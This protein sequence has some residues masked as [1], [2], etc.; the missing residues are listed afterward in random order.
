M[1]NQ[2]FD[3]LET[4]V[5]IGRVLSSDVS[6]T[7]GQ[8]LEYVHRYASQN[9]N[10]DNMV[11]GLYDKSA[12]QLVFTLVYQQGQL[13]DLDSTP[14]DWEPL[15]GDARRAEWIAREKRPLFLP[16]RRAWKVW[17][18]NNPDT[19]GEPV[20]S[21]IGV[22]MM[23]GDK[24]LGVISA[25]HP[26]QEFV[27]NE[28]DLKLLQAVADYAAIALDNK[29][30][31]TQLKSLVKIGREVSAQLNVNEEE[32]LTLIYEQLSSLM[33]TENMYV[34]LYDEQGHDVRFG[35]ARKDG[36][37]VDLD[38]ATAMAGKSRMWWIITNGAPLLHHTRKAGEE[39][40]QQE[41]RGNISPVIFPSYLGVPL[42]VRGK[43]LGVI[44]LY[45][46]NHEYVYNNADLEIL[47]ALADYAAIGLNNAQLYR[48]A[49]NDVIA[50]RNL[51]TLG[52]AM[53]A[54]QHRVYNMFS[55]ITPALES[56]RERVNVNDA[57][58]VN[59]LDDIEQTVS[60]TSGLIGRL[61]NLAASEEE[62]QT[63]HIGT[64]LN[65][66]VREARRLFPQVEFEIQLGSLLP[67]IK[68]PV[69]QINEVFTNLVEN[70]CRVMPQ[71]GK[72]F[73]N[74]RLNEGTNTIE[75]RVQDTG[76]GINPVIQPRL[77]LKP[78]PSRSDQSGSSG[79][80]L[81]LSRLILASLAGNIMIEDTGA[82]GTT[83][84]VILPVR[85]GNE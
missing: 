44:A 14:N 76:P 22:P 72:V 26:D 48:E 6:L 51:A 28:A 39:W 30:V 45:D 60:F 82:H 63:V 84:L 56:L 68:A 54:L 67:V 74:A 57:E 2:P 73:L 17:R 5:R 12:E 49:R 62:A 52:A 79:L 3:R 4:L 78:V 8:I 83:I 32:I 65:T 21:Y 46:P 19:C 55:Y 27:Y 15:M 80:G 66:V 77:F 1:T 10:M 23:V 85:Q 13:I 43:V 34:A 59:I 29:V 11:I 70:A 9:M 18:V 20:A 40:Y 50:A 37:P 25:S 31:N 42:A 69:D 24:L 61:R 53:A 71:G 64:I 7:Q 47:G 58:V 81:W 16:N 36:N 33:S 41:E 35:L 75:V 38:E